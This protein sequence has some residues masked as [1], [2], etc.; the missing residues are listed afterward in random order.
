M[1]ALTIKHQTVGNISEGQPFSCGENVQI[2]INSAAIPAQTCGSSEAVKFTSDG[3]D[4]VMLDPGFIG[5][6]SDMPVLITSKL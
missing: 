6:S 3:A 1:D 2:H 4:L 5:G